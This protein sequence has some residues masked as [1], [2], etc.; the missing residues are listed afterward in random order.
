MPDTQWRQAQ[1]E[2]LVIESAVLSPLCPQR[3]APVSSEFA[4]QTGPHPGEVVGL[5]SGR[6]AAAICSMCR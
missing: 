5:K 1:L 3:L 6:Q 2:V 4:R